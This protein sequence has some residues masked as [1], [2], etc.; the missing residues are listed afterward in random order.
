MKK[1]I[2]YVL[3]VIATACEFAARYLVRGKERNSRRDP[4]WVVHQRWMN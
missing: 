3:V 2:A 1:G 4:K